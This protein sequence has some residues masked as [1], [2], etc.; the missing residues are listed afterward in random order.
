MLSIFAIS[1]NLFPPRGG[2]AKTWL[3]FSIWLGEKVQKQELFNIQ[4]TPIS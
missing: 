3:D 2:Q 4:P 1:V